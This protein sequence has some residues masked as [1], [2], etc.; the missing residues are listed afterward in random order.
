MCFI[1][2]AKAFDWVNQ[3]KLWNI[4]E[5][6]TRREYQ[7]TS[8]ASWETFMQDKKEQLELDMEQ[9]TWF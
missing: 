4:L 7:T 6:N 8:P 5:E 1:D 9:Q 2:D 3:N